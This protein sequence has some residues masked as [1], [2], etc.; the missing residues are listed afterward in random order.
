[1]Q[2]PSIFSSGYLQPRRDEGALLQL[3]LPAQLCTLTELPGS[4]PWFIWVCSFPW[5]EQGLFRFH[6]FLWSTFLMRRG[7]GSSAPVG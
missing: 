7:G 5:E 2:P 6:P 3:R 4:S 1:M